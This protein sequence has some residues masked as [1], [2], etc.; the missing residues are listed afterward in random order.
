MSYK[1]IVG[2][3]ALGALALAVV[4]TAEAQPWGGPGPR[5]HGGPNGPMLGGLRMLDLS[6]E[7]EA[8]V[9]D[10]IAQHHKTVQPIREQQRARMA[11]IQEQAAAP[12]ADPAAIGRLVIEAAAVRKQ[13]DEERDKLRE[14]V[15]ALLTPEQRELWTR[16]E[17][18][19]KKDRA[20][21]LGFGPGPGGGCFG[22]GGDS[23]D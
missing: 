3:I 17:A 20:R 5:R 4:A 22:P 8:A 11:R 12:G 1:K 13:M 9:R 6:E 14:S 18:A 21:G 19:H 2:A 7:Q 15:G 23:D 10:L 16:L